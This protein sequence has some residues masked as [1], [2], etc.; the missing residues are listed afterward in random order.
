MQPV[1]EAVS[2]TSRCGHFRQLQTPSS[3]IPPVKPWFRAIQ[4]TAQAAWLK[5]TPK[6]VPLITSQVKRR[7]RAPCAEIQSR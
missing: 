6:K 7:R 5:V 4:C 2:A 3:Q 1:L